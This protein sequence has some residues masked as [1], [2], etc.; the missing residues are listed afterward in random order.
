MTSPRWL[1]Y[2]RVS[3]DEQAEEGASLPAQLATCRA[4]AQ[5][6]GWTIAEE[7]VDGGYTGTN[8]K[9]PAYQKV[10]EQLRS[11]SVAGVISWKLKRLARSVR[12]WIALMELV[13]ETGTGVAIVMESIDTSTPMGRAIATIM[14]T[15]GQLESEEIGAQ[16]KLAMRYLKGQ[17]IYCGG[18]VPAGC[19]VVPTDDGKRR[20]LIAGPGAEQLRQA[21]GWIAAGDGLKLIAR[22]LND[23]GIAAARRPQGKPPRPWTSTSLRTFLLSPMVTGILV[24]AEVQAHTR[25]I[26]A[27]RA[28]PLRFGSRA[29]P[30]KRAEIPSPL[31]GMLRC[32]RC[33]STMVQVTARGN[34]GSYRYLRCNGRGKNLCRE[35]D[36]RAE[37]V[38]A[39]VLAAVAKAFEPGG[40]YQKQML[41]E[42]AKSQA[43]LADR[44]RE[45][46]VLTAERDQLSARVSS[47]TLQS[48]IGGAA[49]SEAMRLI[50]GELERV[51]ARLAQLQGQLAVADV[52]L[53]SLEFI[54]AELAKGAKDLAQRPAAELGTALRTLVKRVTV[55]A[56]RTILDLYEM[57]AAPEGGKLVRTEVRNWGPTPHPQRTIRV[58]LAR[59]TRPM[60]PRR[61]AL[62]LPGGPRA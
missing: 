26:L 33:G 56:D 14:A 41:A 43:M 42:H 2:A 21:W 53:Q 57:S 45:R 31:A 36:V 17:G 40:E 39:E 32:H 47:L 18:T 19:Q 37:P 28:S 50:S 35:K 60:T 3:T 51:D 62:R 25:A 16:T 38:E 22:R 10:L 9:R 61:G 59:Q 23:L 24:S 20:R 6:R 55:H 54:L 52:D 7:L 4:Y 15:F 12:D 58:E 13:V 34:G 27:G 46:G 5:S 29:A 44:K 48:Q 8:T 1:I 49:W 30:G 11:R